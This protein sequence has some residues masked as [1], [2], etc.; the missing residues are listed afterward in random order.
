M[1]W[2]SIMYLVTGSQIGPVVR[3]RLQ[4]FFRVLLVGRINRSLNVH[5]PAEIHYDGVVVIDLSLDLSPMISR[6]RCK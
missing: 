6:A 2:C 4:G 5:P 3:S 1:A